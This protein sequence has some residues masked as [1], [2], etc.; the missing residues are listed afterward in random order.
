[1]QLPKYPLKAEPSATVFEFTSNGPRGAIRK[2]VLFQETGFEDIFNLAFGDATGT[3][4]FIDDLVITANEDT[5]K[6][7]ATVVEALDQFFQRHPKARVLAVGSTRSRTRLYRMGIS[8]YLLLAQARYD[9]FG[10]I[11]DKFHPFEKDKAYT[12]FLVTLKSR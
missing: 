6:V 10:L 2:L 1:M 12:A 7:L 11:G 3:E 9:I 4:L 5:D 8:R